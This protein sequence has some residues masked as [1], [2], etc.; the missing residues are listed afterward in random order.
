MYV[1]WLPLCVGILGGISDLGGAAYAVLGSTLGAAGAFIYIYMYIHIYAYTRVY[2]GFPFCAGLLDSI[3]DLGG[4]AYKYMY[5]HT[6][7]D[8]IYLHMFTNM[9]VGV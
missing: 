6:Y 9:Y 5:I 7:I 3:S 2:I 1:Y 8:E 4:T